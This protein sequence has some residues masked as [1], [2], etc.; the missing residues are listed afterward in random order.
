MIRS[1]QYRSFKYGSRG[2]NRDLGAAATSRGA[3]VITESVVTAD[4]QRECL[5]YIRGRIAETAVAPSYE[6][7]RIALRLHSKSGVH[8]LIMALER[9]GEI[10]RL[11]HRARAIEVVNP[12]AREQVSPA[13]APVAKPLLDITGAAFYVVEK[14]P[15]EDARLVPMEAK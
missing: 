6:E 11:G 10:R 1:S 9:R 7:I 4:R 3:A 15:G 5:D 12:Q 14:S 2:H 8:R 13:K